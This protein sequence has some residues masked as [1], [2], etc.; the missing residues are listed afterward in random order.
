MSINTQNMLQYN[1][2]RLVNEPM[3][4]LPQ[5]VC[6]TLEHSGMPTSAPENITDVPPDFS[7]MSELQLYKGNFNMD[8]TQEPKTSIYTTYVLNHVTSSD[9]TLRDKFPIP[10]NYLPFLASRWWTGTIS[11]KFIAIKAPLTGGKILIR[12]SYDP[13]FDMENLDKLRRGVAKEWDLSQGSECEFDIEGTFPI[14]ARPTWIPHVGYTNAAPGVVWAPQSMPLPVWNMGFIEC[15]V[16]QRLVPGALFPDRIRILVFQVFK[17]CNFYL[18]TD[19][20]GQTKHMLSF[21]NDEI[22]WNPNP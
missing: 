20:R 16:A 12:Y 3:Q 15:E 8:I 6:A 11:Y 22:T 19:M 18:P 13:N 17:N 10:W 5:T 21:A 1:P 2:P 14:E 4:P 9:G 7:W